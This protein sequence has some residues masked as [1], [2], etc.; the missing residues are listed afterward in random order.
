MK[1]SALVVEPGAKFKLS[2]FA[3]DDTH[4]VSKHHATASLP[5]HVKRLAEQHDLLYAEHKRA[6][7]IVL[8]GM[9]ASGK[10]GTI[11]H[12]MSGV[13]PQGCSV[14]SFKQPSTKELDHDFLWRVHAAVPGKGE[15][16]IFNRSQYEDVL[17]ARV[18]D[19]V[20]RAVWKKRYDQINAFEQILAE[21]DV[22][23]LK[24]FLHIS[25]E[26]QARRFRERLS[27]PRKNWKASAAD[28]KE[29]EYWDKYQ[30]AYQ[31]TLDKCSTKYAPWYVI[32]S[33]HKWFRNFAVGGI[34]V[35]TLESFRMQ[36]PATVP[37]EAGIDTGIDKG[38]D[39]GGKKS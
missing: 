7:L 19:L 32:P 38:E 17:I 3:P 4:G 23:I 22:H 20:P 16:G 27:D 35:E 2:K 28:F 11:R 31:D 33:D 8:Q 9:D 25:S 6:M 5:D 18:H 1:I 26:E 13:N 10:D 14:T 12:V 36:Y 34:I 37:P 29:R 24:F 21:N 30:A 15:I 39:R